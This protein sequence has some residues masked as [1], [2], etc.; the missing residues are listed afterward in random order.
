MLT[1]HYILNIK[2]TPVFADKM[3][4]PT[5]NVIDFK[6]VFGSTVFGIGW[7]L[8]GICPGPAVNLYCQFSL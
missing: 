1:F 3:Q 6:L 2:K 4:V 7:G 5:N 8:G